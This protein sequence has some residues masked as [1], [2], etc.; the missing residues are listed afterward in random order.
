MAFSFI[1]LLLLWPIRKIGW[2][3]SPYLY[4]ANTV[5][6]I[7][8]LTVWGLGVGSIVAALDWRLKPNIVLKIVFGF[9]EGLYLSSPN[10][11]LLNESIIPYERQNRHKLIS[12]YPQA[13][14]AV[15]VLVLFYLNTILP[16]RWNH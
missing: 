11:G 3:L 9:F 12:H 6:C 8:T 7:I 16:K 10:F 5:I 4:K 1:M 2:M 15:V 13:V 14:F